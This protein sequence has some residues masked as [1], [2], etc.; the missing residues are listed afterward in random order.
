[1]KWQLLKTENRLTGFYQSI[2]KPNKEMA[3]G[4][5]FYELM[6]ENPGNHFCEKGKFI[7]N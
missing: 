5:F 1:M 4:L 2:W 7:K 3:D 6:M